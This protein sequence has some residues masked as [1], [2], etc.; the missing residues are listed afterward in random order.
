MTKNYRSNIDFKT[1]AE[2]AEKEPY[3]SPAE[4]DALDLEA[5]ERNQQIKILG[6]GCGLRR[7]EIDS[8]L[9]KNID[10]TEN[11]IHVLTTEFGSTKTTTSELSGQEGEGVCE[12]IVFEAGYAF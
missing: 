1:L 2:A 6:L 3:S 8:L 4:A 11:T 9:W 5:Q 7:A 12:A 10:A